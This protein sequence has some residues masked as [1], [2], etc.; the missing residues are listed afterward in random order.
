LSAGGLYDDSSERWGE[1][2]SGFVSDTSADERIGWM[3]GVAH[4]RRHWRADMAQSL[5][6]A[7]SDI[8]LNQD[9]SI[10]PLTET[11]LHRPGFLAYPL[12]TGERK[13][14]GA[15]G[16]L[17][18]NPSDRLHTT[19]DI[20]YIA[21]DTPEQAT[22]QTN[23]LFQ[24]FRPGSVSVDEN[25]TVTRFVID[26]YVT[27]VAI[28]PKNRSVDLYQVGWN[29]EWQAT[30]TLALTS[31]IAYSRAHRPEGGK[32]KFW[33]AGIPGASAEFT[34]DNPVPSL[35]I[36]LADGRDLSQ[37]TNDEMRVHFMESKGDDIE[38]EILALRL[39]A[40]LKTH[41]GN[42]TS[43]DYGIGY[44]TRNKDKR[45]FSNDSCAYCGY[46]FSFGDAGL[47][48]LVD[49]PY[50]D[51]L[52]GVSGTFPRVWPV[53]DAD[54][55]FA[56]LQA[57]DEVIINPNSGLPY[58]PE[59]SERLLPRGNP[60]GSSSIEESVISTYLQ[61]NF[62]GNAWHGNLGA[63]LANTRLSSS[64]A[65][66]SIL[67][68]EP[69]PGTANSWLIVSDLEPV[70]D[71]NSYTNLL[72]S[73][74]FTLELRDNLLLR[75]AAAEVSSRP[76]LAQL[77]VDVD[78]ETN[79]G[80]RRVSENGNPF[81]DPVTAR[82]SDVSLEWY[83]S[84]SSAVAIAVFYKDIKG[85][86][87]NVTHTEEIVGEDFAVTRPTNNERAKVS[88]VELA[89]HHLF[90]NGLG[91]QANYTYTDSTASDNSQQESGTGLEN[92]SKYSYNLIGIYEKGR[93]ST[94]LALN[95][96]DSYLLTTVG[97][98]GRPETTDKYVQLDFR[99][100]VSVSDSLSLYIEGLNLTGEALHSYSE[101]RNRLIEYE[102]IGRRF[103]AGIRLAF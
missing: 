87:T 76:S 72:P 71:K 27:E 68:L 31:D 99:T 8:D 18:F 85:F 101:H 1:Q 7:F 33:V 50:D 88:G 5:G 98:G 73:A 32:N 81:L 78:I 47:Q 52:S 12:K 103:S 11:G 16:T 67:G 15:V 75:L 64:G 42:I 97:Q 79:I 48:G 66:Q 62:E 24:T 54:A 41:I 13:R 22:Y 100:D 102:Q 94:R 83:L 93:I 10:D 84:D 77:G 44:S 3:L 59:Y 60:R 38:D 69:I 61:I 86:V 21:F 43:L 82:Q 9:G 6:F 51:F 65:R 20:L 55:V 74:N 91:L 90:E 2:L 26:D 40:S 95:Y 37:A 53:L 19:L 96:R 63:R 35:N 56:I 80:V 29:T 57:A 17:Q 4:S 49:F 70:T 14:L 58:T 34:A 39:D 25:G 92:L 28:D 23:N 36:T 46:P 30:N 89:L 45:A